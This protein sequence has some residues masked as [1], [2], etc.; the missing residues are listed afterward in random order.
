MILVPIH[1]F[2]VTADGF[3]YQH[4]ENFHLLENWI[5][6][7][8]ILSSINE[9]EL[10]LRPPDFSPHASIWC[11]SRWRHLSNS[12]RVWG[13]SWPVGRVL[14][15]WA[16]GPGSRLAWRKLSCTLMAPG[17]CK[18]RHGCNVLQVPIQ[19]ILLGIPKRENHLLR[20]GSKLWWHVSGPTVGISHRPSAVVHCI[21]LVRH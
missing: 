12:I 3:I 20:G 9:V 18:I 16:E 13:R 2:D 4:K 14:S 5:C 10:N 8:M 17:A 11:H 1:N 7:S 15:S 6:I 21:S 19:I